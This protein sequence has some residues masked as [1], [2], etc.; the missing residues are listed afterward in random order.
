[1]SKK[2]SISGQFMFIHV[3][4]YK[5]TMKMRVP[6]ATQ[7][8]TTHRE[9]QSTECRASVVSVLIQQ[10]D[11]H[12]EEAVTEPGIMPPNTPIEGASP[13]RE[14]GEQGVGRVTRVCN[15][16]SGFVFAAC[17]MDVPKPGQITH[18]NTNDLSCL[19]DHPL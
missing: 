4:V 17:D 19:P 15:N 14:G 5:N 2:N 8:S 10:S 13:G 9:T 12:W 1:M 6:A 18:I 16:L 11:R 3:H 7:N